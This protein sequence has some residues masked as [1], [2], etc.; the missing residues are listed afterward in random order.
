[1][2]TTL[3]TRFTDL[4]KDIWTDSLSQSWREVCD[5]LRGVVEKIAQKGTDVP[6]SATMSA[7]EL[8]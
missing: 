2:M 1:M 5:E 4:K 8:T 3:P 7:L 6:D